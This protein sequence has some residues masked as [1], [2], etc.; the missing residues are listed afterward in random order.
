VITRETQ[1]HDE[2]LSIE[3][4]ERSIRDT[5]EP[6]AR[7]VVIRIAQLMRAN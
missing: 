1:S 2:E 6:T 5:A 4:R 3:L 7:G